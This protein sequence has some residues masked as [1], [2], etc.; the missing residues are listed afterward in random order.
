MAY[1]PA[2]MHVKLAASFES[3]PALYDGNY[4]PAR[5]PILPLKNAII[6]IGIAIV[7][8]NRDRDTAFLS[9]T[10]IQK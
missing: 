2:A 7:T 3:P 5:A 6:G 8:E 4:T 10:L 1:S 9:L